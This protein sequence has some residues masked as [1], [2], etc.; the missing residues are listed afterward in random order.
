[1]SSEVVPVFQVA[2]VAAAVEHYTQ[3]LG[4]DEEFRWGEYAG[5]CFAGGARLH[6]NA[7]ESGRERVGQ[8]AAYF[9]VSEVDRIYA[10]VVEAGAR[11]D[12]P[13]GDQAYGM[14]DF[15]VFDTDGNR[16]TFGTEVVPEVPTQSG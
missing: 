2:D 12:H 4:F 6:L 5:V 15:S 8:G 7:F 14:R 11:I 16:L 10:Q 9:F 13:L 3:V 1:M